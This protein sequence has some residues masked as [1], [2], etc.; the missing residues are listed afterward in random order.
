LEVGAFYTSSPYYG[1]VFDLI[2]AEGLVYSIRSEPQSHPYPPD[3]RL[4][5][6]DFGPEYAPKI[7]VAIDIKPGSDPGSINP[8]SH[9][10]IPV[11]ILGSESFDVTNIDLTTLTFGPDGATPAHRRGGHAEDVN[12]NGAMDLVSHFRT[13]DTGIT[14]ETDQVCVSGKM[15]DGAAFE[16]CSAI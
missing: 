10:V 15:L 2:V 5:I 16:G 13:Q 11:A 8:A 4:M 6:V 14:S 7:G 12:G 9:G 1:E 3:T